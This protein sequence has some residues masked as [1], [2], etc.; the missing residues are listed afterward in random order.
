MCLAHGKL[1]INASNTHHCCYSE[2]TSQ[3]GELRSGR[4]SHSTC[5]KTQPLPKGESETEEDDISVP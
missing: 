4:A 2:K 1:S 5:Q 3:K